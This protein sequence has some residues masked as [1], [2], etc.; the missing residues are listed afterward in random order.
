MVPVASK[1]D[2][3]PASQTV[4]SLGSCGIQ[5]WEGPYETR[6]CHK[7]AGPVKALKPQTDPETPPQESMFP[8]FLFY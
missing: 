4:G 1:L 6:E 8:L 7:A 5:V 2:G 3:A